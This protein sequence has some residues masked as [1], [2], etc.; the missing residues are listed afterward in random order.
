MFFNRPRKA[1]SPPLWLLLA[2]SGH[3][4]L[5]T[6]LEAGPPD[7]AHHDNSELAPSYM[8]LDPFHEGHV[9]GAYGS[10]LAG[11]SNAGPAHPHNIQQDGENFIDHYIHSNPA[12]PQAI[13]SLSAAQL[14]RISDNKAYS[15]L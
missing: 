9:W 12:N 5:A 13:V 14:Q 15:A 10:D 2:G 11:G 6:L 4:H 3:H 1:T 7:S 8:P